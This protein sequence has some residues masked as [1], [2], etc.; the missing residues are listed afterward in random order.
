MSTGD[1]VHPEPERVAR[2]RATTARRT[3]QSKQEAPHFYLDV[4]VNMSAV[5]RFRES[6]AGDLSWSAPPTYTAII[7]HVVAGL[8]E[9]FPDLN[10]TYTDHGPVA[11]EGIGIGVAVATPAG[12]LVPVLSEANSS[13]LREIADWLA[14]AAERAHRL[15]LKP[16]DLSSKSLVVSNL[17]SLGV[18]RFHA[19]IDPSD[20]M[21]LTVG[22][23]VDRVIAEDGRA[24]VAP[25]AT[26]SLS[27]DHRVLDG[28]AGARFLTALREDIEFADIAGGSS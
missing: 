17:G 10:V 1:G 8:L 27:I 19:I 28:A 20:P 24:T 13:S 15:R 21:I 5:R 2:I 4:D 23:I 3:M 22:R 18:D 6:L 11:I 12:L 7:V 14:A 16:D 9:R 25:M 26:F